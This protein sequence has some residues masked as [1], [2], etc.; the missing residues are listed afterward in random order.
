MFDK[1]YSTKSNCGK[2]CQ[3]NFPKFNECSQNIVFHYIGMVHY[4]FESSFIYTF[5]ISITSV[6]RKI[7]GHVIS[8]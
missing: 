5:L 7:I 4:T 1:V 8:V 3:R 6:Q 2:T